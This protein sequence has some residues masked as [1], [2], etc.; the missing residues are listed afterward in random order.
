MGL[1][2]EDKT[3]LLLVI[4]K[5]E[6]QYSYDNANGQLPQQDWP[7]SRPIAGAE[8][9]GPAAHCAGRTGGG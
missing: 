5:G 1:L 7:Q 8:K 6:F 9:T 2:E 4:E 3:D